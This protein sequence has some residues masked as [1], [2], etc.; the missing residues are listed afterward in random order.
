MTGKCGCAVCKVVGLLVI[1]GAINWG[2]VGAFQFDLVIK[3]LGGSPTPVRIVYILIGVAGLVKFITC[4]KECPM[5]K[6]T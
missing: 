6:K 3:L 5:C 1:L 2:L 4:F